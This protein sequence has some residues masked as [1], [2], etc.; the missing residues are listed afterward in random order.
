MEESSVPKERV[1]LNPY[2]SVAERLAKH[3]IPIKAEFLKP[4]YADLEELKKLRPSSEAPSVEVRQDDR[5]RSNGE[6]SKKKGR[7]TKSSKKE[8]AERVRSELFQGKGICNVLVVGGEC[9]SD[10]CNYSHD[11]K[12]F[13][14]EQPA[15]ISD[16]CWV[17][18]Q[19]GS[20]P[21]GFRCRFSSAHMADGKLVEDSSITERR[22]N[23]EPDVVNVIT[24][25]VQI[26]LRKKRIPFTRTKAAVRK[27][28]NGD[29][30]FLSKVPNAPDAVDT[31][32][33]VV[34]SAEDAKPTID[35]KGKLI[36]APLTTIGNLPY[37]RICKG[38]GVDITVGEMALAT[39][40]LAV[41]LLLPL[42]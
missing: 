5:D 25:D 1:N 2:L 42:V 33:I 21:H 6:P 12:A 18:E 28:A 16:R 7:Y 30:G 24:K 29:L 41:R 37:R 36:L 35:W 27:H 13:L 15:S 31:S 39:Q 34:P 38:Y 8:H 17:F 32:N 9:S 22:A 10:S 14:E 3:E 40:L 4:V 11:I 26:D 20:C 23:A 19:L